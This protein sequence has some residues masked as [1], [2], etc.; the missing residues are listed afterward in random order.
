MAGFPVMGSIRGRSGA[1]RKALLSTEFSDRSHPGTV[2]ACA[3]KHEVRR[4][5]GELCASDGS[6]RAGASWRQ[7]TLLMDGA[8]GQAVTLGA[9]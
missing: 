8:Y 1:D 3:N 7:L 5:L 4:G 6:S 2:I 9:S